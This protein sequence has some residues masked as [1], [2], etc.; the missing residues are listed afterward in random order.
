MII[1]DHDFGTE[2]RKGDFLFVFGNKKSSVAT[3][4]QAY[5]QI[6]FARLK[7]THGD[8]CVQSNAHEAE[9]L[10]E[11]DAHWT[12]KTNLALC[13]STADCIPVLIADSKTNTIAAIH[14]GWKGV[15]NRIVPKTIQILLQSGVEL[16]KIMTLIGPHIQRKSFEVQRDVFVEL[17]NSISI[18]PNDCKDFAESLS[19]KKYLVD[20]NA[21]IKFQIHQFGIE[22]DQV[23]DLHK[24]TKTDL[25]FHSHR[26]DQALAG[27]QISFV[28]SVDA[29]R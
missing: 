17:M 10:T 2:I 11:A 3:F 28:A 24:D 14:A 12:T 13:I 9:P 27:R 25:L 22:A 26:R 16:K 6:D 29:I 19:E 4:Q 23:F 21:I 5:P 7:Q 15:A 1:K 8:L 18:D 20:L